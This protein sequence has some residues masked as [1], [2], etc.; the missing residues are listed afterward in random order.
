MEQQNLLRENIAAK[1]IIITG[2]TVIDS[3]YW[4]L[5]HK[6]AEVCSG[7]DNIIIVT[8]HRRENLGSNINNICLAI[9]ELNKQF[10]QMNFVVPIHPNPRVQHAIKGLLAGKAGIHLLPPLRYDQF[11]HLMNRCRLILTDSGGIQEEAPA[12]HKPVVVLRN[13]TERPAIINEGVGILAGTSTEKIVAIVSQ[14]LTDTNLYQKMA[15][16]SSPYGDGHAAG[17]IIQSL[18]EGLISTPTLDF[19]IT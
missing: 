14:L 17:R 8:T 10:P 11:V 2:N 1:N 5:K 12:L 15:S 9:L 6:K 19:L 7:L 3:V 13:T 4:V 18:Y 16:G